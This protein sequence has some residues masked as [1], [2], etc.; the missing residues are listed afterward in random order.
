MRG[1]ILVALAAMLWGTTG[2][3]QALAPDAATPIVVGTMRLVF[4]GATLLLFAQLRG[5]L[6]QWRGLM[7]PELLWASISVAAY[8]LCFFAAVNLT[9]VTVGTMVGLGSAPILAGL[10]G[11]LVRG[12][13]LTQRWMSATALAVI[14]CVILLSSG[15]DTMVVDTWGVL[16]ALGAGLS[17]TIFTLAHKSLSET[18]NGDGA[19]ALTFCFG[20]LI[21]LPTLP[22]NDT[23]WVFTGRGLLVLLHLGVLATGVSYLLFG[24]GLKTVP[25]ATVGTLTLVEPLTAGLLGLF[26]LGERLT[27]F[28]GL[29]IALLFVGLVVLISAPKRVV[30]PEAANFS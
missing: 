2:T 16:L 14:G 5:D 25:V 13:Q 3:S 12:E 20:A 21:L 19:M 26:L 11:Y 30:I 24:R 15:G 23:S 6:Q 27:L 9:G 28:A 10:A 29:G 18:S 8:Q 4:G 1:M 17:Y 7:R 22:F